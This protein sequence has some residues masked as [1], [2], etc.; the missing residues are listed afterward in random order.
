MGLTAQPEDDHQP[1][2]QPIPYTGYPHPRGAT[3]VLVS[4]VPAFKSCNAP[5]RTHGAPLAFASCNPPQQASD[6]LTVG[7]PDSNGRAAA[8][9]GSLRYT[10]TGA[11]TATP[12][13]KIDVSI[14]GVLNKTVLTPYGGELSADGGLRI[15]DGNNIPNPGGPGP[16]TV[17]DTSFPVTV[18]CSGSSCAISTTANAVM[19]GSVAGGNR[20]VWQLGQVKVYDGGSDGLASTTV[21]NTLFMDQGVFTP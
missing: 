19:P 18:P 9:V 17:Q 2:W 8:S 15:T 12:D 7:T 1:D 21:D 10:V 13:L 16:G 11:S 5:N 14:T 20:T 3:P 6:F 4:L